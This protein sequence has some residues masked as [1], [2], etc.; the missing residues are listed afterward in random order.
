MFQADQVE[1][2]EL[3]EQDKLSIHV[4]SL[5]PTP[6]KVGDTSIQ[7]MHA[8][9]NTGSR[10]IPLVAAVTTDQQRIFQSSHIWYNHRR[11]V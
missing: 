8:T 11:R 7:A 4:Y 1:K 6:V 5:S 3:F 10:T 9:D 2:K